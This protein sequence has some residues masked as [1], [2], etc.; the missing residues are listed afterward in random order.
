MGVREC[1]VQHSGDEQH[2]GGGDSEDTYA[3][4]H[5]AGRPP[6]EMWLPQASHVSGTDSRV[7]TAGWRLQGPR[8]CFG[9][10]SS[11]C[12]ASQW[13][14]DRLLRGAQASPDLGARRATP[15]L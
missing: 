3:H 15:H 1:A 13:S 2:H 6:P 8:A 10:Q 9:Q 12:E 11:F 5:S 4:F 14:A 7:G